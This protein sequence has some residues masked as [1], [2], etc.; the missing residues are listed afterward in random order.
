MGCQC[1]RGE[2]TGEN[3]LPPSGEEKDDEASS[4][5]SS[6]MMSSSQF[7]TDSYADGSVLSH[8]VFT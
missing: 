7:D 8:G 2:N 1:I 4:N 5:M 6:I 3:Y